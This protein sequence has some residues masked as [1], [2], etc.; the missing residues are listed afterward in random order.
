MEGKDFIQHFLTNKA[1]KMLSQNIWHSR[2]TVELIMLI[3]DVS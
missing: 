1:N 2:G 3:L